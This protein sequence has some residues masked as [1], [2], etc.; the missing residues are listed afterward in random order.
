MRLQLFYHLG[1]ALA[2]GSAVLYFSN[3]CGFSALRAEKPHTKIG[4]Y[5]AAAGKT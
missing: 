4:K 3:V 2:C 5:H 1:R